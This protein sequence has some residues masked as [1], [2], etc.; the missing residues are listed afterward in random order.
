MRTHIAWGSPH[1]QD[2][3]EAHGSPLGAEEIA[4]T[5][6]AYGWPAEP[7]FLVPPTR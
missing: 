6:E 2:T 3:A 4:L 1:K 5:K 7:P